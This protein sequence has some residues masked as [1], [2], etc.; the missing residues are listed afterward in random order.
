MNRL[1]INSRSFGRVIHQRAARTNMLTNK[2]CMGGGGGGPHVPEGYARLGQF[3]LVSCWFWIL[4]RAKENRGQLFGLYLPW[5]DEHE[6]HHYHYVEDGDQG[7]TMP[8]LEEAH[9]DEHDEE[10]DEE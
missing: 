9:D 1:F 6:H 3:C 4:Y 8:L 5:L 10:E 7:D 2:R